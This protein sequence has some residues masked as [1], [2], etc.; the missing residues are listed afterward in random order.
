MATSLVG[1]QIVFGGILISSGFVEVG[2]EGS[3][4]LLWICLVDLGPELL[5]LSW[6]R[7]IDNIPV[8]TLLFLI[9]YLKIFKVPMDAKSIYF[10][11]W[12][13]NFR[14]GRMSIRPKKRLLKFRGLDKFPLAWWY[15]ST[16]AHNPEIYTY[17]YISIYFVKMCLCSI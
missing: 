4:E 2:R 15:L 8:T 13:E 16:L 5:L 10:G 14:S 17:I 6:I 12:V 7:F 9:L 11:K 1:P 3:R